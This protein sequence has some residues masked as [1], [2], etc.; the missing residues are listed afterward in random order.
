MSGQLISSRCRSARG[1]LRCRQ[2]GAKESDV[3]LQVIVS[4]ELNDKKIVLEEN[5]FLSALIITNEALLI[6]DGA[7]YP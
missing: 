7:T 1:T 4:I 6:A 2:I 5:G 3:I